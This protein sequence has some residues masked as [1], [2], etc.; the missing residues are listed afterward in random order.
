MNETPKRPDSSGAPDSTQKFGPEFAQKLQGLESGV[1]LEEQEIIAAL[2]SRSALLIVRKGPNAG[3]RFLL[4]KDSKLRGV[5]P[6][7]IFSS[8]TSQS[9][10]V[11]QNSFDTVALLK[12]KILA[13]LMAPILMVC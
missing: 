3:A 7:L 1:S 6:R 13:R 4:D 9:H 5:T 8:M 10:G 11:T 12:S 2:P